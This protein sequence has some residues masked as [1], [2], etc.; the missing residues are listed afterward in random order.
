[1]LLIQPYQGP[2]TQ[3]DKL[4]S[5]VKKASESGTKSALVIE[6]A[7]MFVNTGLALEAE[8]YVNKMYS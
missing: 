7:A 6:D 1:M 3:K 4:Q 5:L 2:Q 8:Q